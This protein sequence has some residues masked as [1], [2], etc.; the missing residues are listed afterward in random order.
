MKPGSYTKIYIHLVFAV[1]NRENVLHKG[2]RKRI[3]EYLSG[4][5]A[6]LGHKSIIVNGVTDHVHVF[7]GMNPAVSVS[8]TV[9]DLKR[10]SSLFINNN[11]FCIGKFS[12]QEG[13]GGFSY[14]RSQIN[15]V[16]SYIE[17]QES[18]HAKKTFREE[19]IDLLKEF[20]ID[21]DTRYIFDFFDESV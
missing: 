12:W 17:N 20:E 11:K 4:I 19:Y 9:H 7:Y 16:Y 6:N 18:H 14:N 10:S 13:Y 21:Y 1:K 2:I 3:F 5:L 15:I 8:D